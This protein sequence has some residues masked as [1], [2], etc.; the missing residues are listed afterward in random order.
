KITSEFAYP[1][2][3]KERSYQPNAD[4][5]AFD[6][7]VFDPSTS[8]IKSDICFDKLF[9]DEVSQC[10]R[11]NHPIFDQ[12]K[13]KISENKYNVHYDHLKN[14]QD[15]NVCTSYNFEVDLQTP[16]FDQNE[17]QCERITSVSS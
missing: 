2:A 10:L 4:L 3:I 9:I 1:I 17:T 6:V 15:K 13:V 11:L 7:V 8:L 14:D 16:G 12:S 5:Y